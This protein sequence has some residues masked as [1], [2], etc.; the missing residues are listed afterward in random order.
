MFLVFGVV[1]AKSE[2]QAELE[3]PGSGGGGKWSLHHGTWSYQLELPPKADGRRRNLLSR[4]GFSSQ[5]EADKEII[6]ITELLGISPDHQT[7]IKVADLIV[8]TIKKTRKLP[9]AETV[10]RK[11]RTGQQLNRKIL[12][13]DWLDIWLAGKKKIS[14]GTR[15]RYASDVRLYL[16][17]YLGHI[18]VEELR[19]VDIAEMFDGIEEYND[20]IRKPDVD[21]K[22]GAIG[23]NWQITQRGWNPRHGKPKTDAGDRII[24]LDTDTIKILRTH[25]ARQNRERLAA[26]LGE[27]ESFFTDETGQPL[28]PAYVTDQLQ[29]LAF[30]AGLPPIRL[31]DLRHGAASLMLAAG[32]D[33]K[34]VQHTLGHVTSAY[35]RDTYTSVYPHLARDAA[36]NTAALLTFPH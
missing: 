8:E 14:E 33:I 30:D 6:Q 12:L 11:V 9:N 13:S 22:N 32:V 10:C 21:L 7:Q 15:D 31:H 4:A 17:P 36:E 28:H 29:W 5:D 25:Q 3:R 16:K 1:L 19:V 20:V 23:I 34:I 2:A 27:S 18:P 24:E 35:T 26:G